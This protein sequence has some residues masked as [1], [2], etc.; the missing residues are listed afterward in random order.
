MNKI[1]RYS[2]MAL[3]AIVGMNK[4][5]AD[6]F[7]INF[8]EMDL[9]TSASGVTD[10][11]LVNGWLW[12]FGDGIVINVSAKEE[13]ANAENRFWKT[14]AGPQLRCYSGTITINSYNKA[15]T[16]INFVNAKWN[17]GNTV[18][19]GTLEGNLWS[20]SANTV[21]LSIAG[22]TQINKIILTFGQGG[23]EGPTE[24]QT[25]ET[26]IDP[27]TAASM[28]DQLGEGVTSDYPY[29]VS[30]KV[31]TIDQITGGDNGGATF[32]IGDGP[33]PNM[34]IKAYR[35][36]GL[37]NKAIENTAFLK[38]GDDIVVFGYMQKYKDNQGNIIREIINGY[39]YSVNGSTEDTSENPEDAITKGKTEDAPMTVDDVLAYINNFPDYYTTNGSYFIYG[40]CV[41]AP[42]TEKRD[43][44]SYYG[45]A[46]FYIS[47]TPNPAALHRAGGNQLY[48]YQVR[49]LEN[50][51]IDRD[52]YLKVGDEVVITGK[53]TKY[54]KGSEIIPEVKSGYIYKLNG[55]TSG[56]GTIKASIDDNAPAY[57]VG[58][59]RVNEGYKG[60]IIKGGR[61]LI[62]K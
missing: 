58:G 61:K 17:D 34:P 35:L 20:G 10:G 18:D 29:Y 25:P 46:S 59:Q 32:I 23:N 22:N 43:D 52:D 13:G 39:V 28:I 27:L 53:L 40:Y 47:S 5:W 21:V 9:P 60:L 14:N 44:G 31:V 3:L 49:G 42:E 41:S 6:E 37:G 24:G 7:V 33:S 62:Q 57:N 11:D 16:G 55:E 30:G 1:L 26:A 12:Q 36:K 38:E 2:L 15:M 19:T 56:V 50:K 51:K 45:N 54:K 8:N 48:V 4:A